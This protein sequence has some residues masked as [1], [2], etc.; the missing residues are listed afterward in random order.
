MIAEIVVAVLI[1]AALIYTWRVWMPAF[2]ALVTFFATFFFLVLLSVFVS[3][4]SA[5]P[6]LY[7]RVD[8]RYQADKYTDPLIRTEREYQCGNPQF[9]GEIGWQG[10]RFGAY[11]YHDSWLLCGTGLNHKP[12]IYANGIG[13]F[14]QWGGKD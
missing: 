4:C 13:V 7:A 5:V 9:H 12:E 1:A 10:E 3:G 11:A 2:I 14:A 6:E 8:L